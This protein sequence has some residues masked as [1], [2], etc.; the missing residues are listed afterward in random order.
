MDNSAFF[1]E[2]R[3]QI[4]AEHA[5]L[6]HPFVKLMV[7]GELTR[8]QV[9]GWARQFWVIPHTHLTNN[10]GK[11]AHAQM[12]SGGWMQQM[13]ESP[14]D[15]EITEILGESLSD[16]MG[17]SEL[18]PV[19][20]FDGYLDLVDDLGIPRAEVGDPAGLLPTSVTFMYCWT[21]SALYFPL[22][23]LLSSHNMVNDPVNI[24]AYPR[25]CNALQQ[26]YGVSKKGASWFDLHGEVDKE[27]GPRAQAIV[28]R[29]IKSEADRRVVRNAVKFGLGVRWTLYSGIYDA[30][31]ART[32]PLPRALGAGA[33]AA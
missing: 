2:L 4:V 24:L 14:Y 1:K 7:D 18:S 12:L 33:G 11:L 22:L 30:Y 20:H 23:E 19:N 32:L 29:L 16:E 9:I 5:S 26:H 10:A 13:L 28:D 3:E 6:H 17:K 27:H 25:I 8:E 21:S 15:R 31:V